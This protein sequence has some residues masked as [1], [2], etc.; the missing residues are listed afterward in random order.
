MS[1]IHPLVDSGALRPVS[2]PAHNATDP[3]ELERPLDFTTD[4]LYRAYRVAVARWAARLGGPG[5]DVADV[6]QEV[7]LIVHRKLP[8]YRPGGR[9]TT[10]IYQITENVVRH[11]R[12]R[13]R[14][15]RFIGLGA[16]AEPDGIDQNPL[17]LEQIERKEA[18][19]LV[20]RALDRLN[21]QQRSALILFEL[22]GLSGEEIAERL[23]TKVTTV[24]VWLHRGRAAFFKELQ[25]LGVTHA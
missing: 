9:V 20:Y 14:V 12:R 15:R 10:W 25:R 22:E 5:L 24:W 13:A 8:T 6:V 17:P 21:E 7:F 16:S 11:W 4:G 3:V 18:R 19:D 1:V 2:V 23:E